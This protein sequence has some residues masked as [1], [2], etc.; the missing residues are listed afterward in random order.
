MGRLMRTSAEEKLEIIRLVEE[1]GLPVKQVLSE[2]DIP[3]STFYRWY[4]A[5]QSRG[6]AGLVDRSLRSKRIWNRIPEPMQEQ[7]VATALAQP[8][9]SP[10]ELACHIVDQQAYFISE[11]S[12]YRIL[13]RFDLVTSP[14]FTVITSAK[15]FKHP[16][17]RVHELWQTDFTQFKVVGWGWYY[18]STVLDDFSR[19]ILA[20]TLNTSMTA[21]DVQTT[22]D[23]ALAFS[24]VQQAQVHHRPRLLS[25]N[26]PAFLSRD[27]A[28]FLK[29]EQL[30]HIRGKPF[31]PMTQGKIERYHRS[32]KNVICL[33]NYYFPWN[34]EKAVEAFVHFYN[35]QRYH[36]ALNNVTP[37]D[38]YFGRH[39]QILDDRAALKR[40]TLALRRTQYLL[41]SSSA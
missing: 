11:S 26:G 12:V 21:G 13:K 5:Y 35:N 6:E 27:L 40:R 41:D 38:V 15:Q 2:L 16:T 24:G 37:A 25:D 34:L 7:V 4:S 36:E 32:L 39:T 8:E 30:T 17:K 10:R 14:A 33:D 18:L 28:A 9:L 31:H 3:R 22:L 19:Y 23:K 29:K 1:S 20:W